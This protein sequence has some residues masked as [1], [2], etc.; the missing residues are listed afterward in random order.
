[1]P[2]VKYTGETYADTQ[3]FNRYV[4][5]GSE[6]EVQEHVAKKLLKAGDWVL[7]SVVET[8]TKP[9]KKTYRVRKPKKEDN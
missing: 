3:I 8:D 4:Y 6:F 1:M 9:A 5:N 2:T 7:V